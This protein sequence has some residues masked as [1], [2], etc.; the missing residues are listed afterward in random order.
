[1]QVALFIRDFGP[2]KA[3]CM[4]L[5]AKSFKLPLSA[6]KEAHERSRP[7]ERKLFAR[8]DPGFPEVL[9]QTLASLDEMGCRWS[10]FEVR[11]HQTWQPNVQYYEYT[12]ERFKNIIRTDEEIA[13]EQRHFAELEAGEDEEEE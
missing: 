8:S 3:K 7:I 12:I 10:A 4:M 2:N 13:E 6:I 1:M 5:L 9:S 11:D